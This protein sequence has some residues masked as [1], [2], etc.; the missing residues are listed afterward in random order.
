LLWAGIKRVIISQRDPNPMV[1]GGGLERLVGEGIEVVEGVMSNLSS[2]LMQGFLHWCRHRRPLVTAK[3][4]VDSQGS[5]DDLNQ[6]SSRF[7]SHQS[8]ELSH[9]LRAVSDS[10]LVGIGTVLRDD[11]MLTVRLC[12]RNRHTPPL[13]VILDPHGKML[14]NSRVNSIDAPTLQFVSDSSERFEHVE[15]S[16]L[17][18]LL[19]DGGLW[20]P[21][22]ICNALGDREIHELLIEGGPKTIRHFLDADF[23]D[24]FIH[25]KSPVTHVEPLFGFD[26][27]R[28]IDRWPHQETRHMGGD[29]VSFFSR[30]VLPWKEW[31]RIQ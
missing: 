16:D 7:T 24:R 22:V 28:Y 30:E 11:P 20:N 10:I 13:R 3:M 26:I 25:I 18:P 19:D 1:C 21:E 31:P 23:V 5:V 17:G 27:D 29:E 12:P 15:C 9:Q 2:R 8:L 6:E 4:A 14:I